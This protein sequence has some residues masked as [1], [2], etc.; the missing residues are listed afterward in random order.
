MSM[1]HRPTQPVL[2]PRPSRRRAPGIVAATVTTVALSGLAL[3][4]VASAGVADRAADAASTTKAPD[5]ALQAGMDALVRDGALPGL[6]MSVRDPDGHVTNYTAGVGD[7]RTGRK[8]PTDG[9]AR[10]ASITKMYTAVV[11]LQ[12]VGEGKLALDDTVEEHLP[13]VVRGI[14][15]GKAI[16][17]RKITIRQLLQHTSGMPQYTFLDRGILP[18]RNRFF[19]PRELVDSTLAQAPIFAPGEKGKW[20]Y[21]NSGYVLLGLVAQRVTGRPLAELVQDRIVDRLGLKETYYPG[22]GVRG[23]RSPHPQGYL[24]APERDGEVAKGDLVDITRFDPSVAGA[25]GQM[26]ATPSDVNEFLVALKD[27]RLL[28]APE[29]A[30]MQETVRSGLLPGWTYGLGAI[31]MELGCG[32]TALGHGGDADGFQSRAAITPDGRAVTIVGT[33]DETQIYE[34]VDL[35]EKALCAE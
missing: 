2:G 23:I 33:N 14:G 31:E 10:I 26:I 8:V 34:V 7:I 15:K 19:E 25:A 29:L 12:L 32:I 5:R 16:D 21:S 4:G 35:F 22:P 28:E 11:I 27:G 30:A 24:F 17:G 3:S 9:Y 20:A 1:F 13:G 6:L 18:I